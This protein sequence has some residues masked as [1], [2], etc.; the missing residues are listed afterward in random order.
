MLKPYLGFISG[1]VCKRVD[2]TEQL[3]S[4]RIKGVFPSYVAG[5]FVKLA[6]YDDSQELIRRAYSIVNHPDDHQT[7]S[8]LEFLI[9][10][11]PEGLLSPKL[12]KLQL[13]HEVLVSDGAAGFMTLDEIPD[14]VEDLW[15]LSTGTAIGPFLAMLGNDEIKDRFKTITLVNA[16]RTKADQ[17]YLDRINELKIKFEKGFQYVPVISRESISGTLSGRIPE[18]LKDGR[19]FERAGYFPTTEK[20][21]FYLCGNPEMVKDTSNGLKELGFT[22]HLRKNAVSSAAKIIGNKFK[23]VRYESFKNSG[24]L[25]NSTFYSIFHQR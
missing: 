9:V 22:K 24:R 17:S 21:F 11:D 16:T 8:E 1:I 15:L 3:V 23:E 5:Q 12:H 19:L 2:W 6:L 20:S 14:D 4:L 10:A 18:L 7:T 13:G 25:D